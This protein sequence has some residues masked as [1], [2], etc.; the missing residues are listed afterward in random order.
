MSA[1]SPPNKREP[2]DGRLNLRA[3]TTQKELISRAAAQT[4]QSVTD[5]VL[6]S[7]VDTAHNVLADQR[8]FQMSEE[9]WDWFQEFLDSPPKSMPRLKRLLTEP[10]MS[11]DD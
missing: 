2:R 6:R 8:I 7:A 10:S 3:S 11:R 5:F 1:I 4:G 9:E